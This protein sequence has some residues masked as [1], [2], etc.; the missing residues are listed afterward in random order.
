MENQNQNQIAPQVTAPQ[1]EVAASMPPVGP[2]SPYKKIIIGLASIMLVGGIGTFAY[3]NYAILQAED[4]PPSLENP[5]DTS[6]VKGSFV[7]TNQNL[8]AFEKAD[9]D[10][11]AEAKPDLEKEFTT[12]AVIEPGVNYLYAD[13]DISMAEIVKGIDPV[14]HKMLLAYYSPGEK[15]MK[16]GFYTY[17]KGPFK[18]TNEIKKEDL[19]TFKI[20]KNRV[21]IVISEMASS[22]YGLFDNSIS[23]SKALT[24]APL[25]D[26]E[27]GWVLIASKE[28][29]IATLTSAYQKRVL[30]AYVLKT[31]SDFQKVDPSTYKLNEESIFW[32]KLNTKNGKN[33]GDPKTSETKTDNPEDKKVEVKPDTSPCSVNEYL[34]T[35][36]KKVPDLATITDP[37]EIAAACALYSDLLSEKIVGKMDPRTTMNVQAIAEDPLCKPVTPEP[38]PGDTPLP[39]SLTILTTPLTLQQYST[40]FVKLSGANLAGATIT[41]P[42]DIT[43]LSIMIP[44]ATEKAITFSLSAK[45][46]APPGETKLEIVAA[47]GKKYYQP[48]VVTEIPPA[49]PT[50]KFYA[51]MSQTQGIGAVGMGFAGSGFL[52][53]KVTT[54]SD[55]TIIDQEIIDANNIKFTVNIGDDVTPGIKEFTVTTPEGSATDKSLD[56]KVKPAPEVQK[57]LPTVNLIDPAPVIA[58][59]SGMDL[60]ITGTN[61]GQDTMV[62]PE[63]G[64]SIQLSGTKVAADGK[65]ITTHV[66]TF[67]NSTSGHISIMAS[68][69][70]YHLQPI[71]V[72]PWVD[73]NKDV[74]LKGA[75]KVVLEKE[76]IAPGQSSIMTITGGNVEYS[77]PSVVGPDEK[78]DANKNIVISMGGL[79][80]DEQP[81]SSFAQER[82]KVQA[83][84][85]AAPGIYKITVTTGEKVPRTKEISITV[86]APTSESL[87]DPLVKSATGITKKT[88]ADKAPD[89]ITMYLSVGTDLDIKTLQAS[90]LEFQALSSNN[91]KTATNKDSVSNYYM[92]YAWKL[93]DTTQNKT[94]LDTGW[95]GAFTGLEPSVCGTTVFVPG[96]YKNKEFMWIC[97]FGKI[98]KDIFKDVKAGDK[99]VLTGSVGDGAEGNDSKEG[100]SFTVAGSVAEGGTVGGTVKVGETVLAQPGV[101]VLADFLYCMGDTPPAECKTAKLTKATNIKESGAVA[102]IWYP[103]KVTSINLLGGYYF[104]VEFLNGPIDVIGTTAFGLPDT[105]IARMVPPGGL[106]DFQK[107]IAPGRKGDGSYWNAHILPQADSNDLYPIY[108]YDHELVKGSV[109]TK[110]TYGENDTPQTTPSEL[111]IPYTD[112]IID[113]EA[114]VGNQNVNLNKSAPIRPGPGATSDTVVSISETIPDTTSPAIMAKEG[115]EVL[116]GK[117]VLAHYKDGETDTVQWL[118]ANVI[119][120]ATSTS[121][122]KIQYR[123]KINKSNDG[124]YSCDSDA[125]QK[126][127]IFET[128]K[129]R[130]ALKYNKGSFSK[131]ALFV[132]NTSDET[133]QKNGSD[134]S[135]GGKYAGKY[136]TAKAISP[137][138][139]TL[140]LVAFNYVNKN[141]LGAAL[142]KNI[143]IIQK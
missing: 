32:L 138:D 49:P 77:S 92:N 21:V 25:G 66:Q 72:T 52:N 99:L 90:G 108:G 123:C 94:L 3:V 50:I 40:I 114:D 61:L 87:S 23:P 120:D 113:L 39:S 47:D 6:G 67:P 64:N 104:T 80:A 14:A 9:A 30:G 109:G 4:R 78:D 24:S 79:G 112:P 139:K 41:T 119:E 75:L 102:N 27:Y 70:V 57:T 93:V 29:N 98:T 11:F 73:P 82:Q 36:C 26:N 85:A 5:F 63:L 143:Y 16:A 68:D 7:E 56:V 44:Y 12:P 140:L 28:K 83:K 2:S 135:K 91:P 10:T 37:K 124:V 60:T 69:K 116:K 106:K 125:K 22:A 15:N 89:P 31:Q 55:V 33:Y 84:V 142:T 103:A 43:G 115:D 133:E 122:M 62:S 58:G 110:N 96:T 65:S 46:S 48:V 76:S 53:G 51:P 117:I 128:T 45:V 130:I 86:T 136:V 20:P 111:S 141:T 38:K 17:P 74:D 132:I 13:K 42:L 101:A 95:T 121:P 134:E 97:P 8:L 81:N 71:T 107:V 100:L 126:T 54:T 19:V 1:Q 118:Q 105:A 129:D 35:T 34:D 127:S 131:G 59:G 18:A 88:A 137:A